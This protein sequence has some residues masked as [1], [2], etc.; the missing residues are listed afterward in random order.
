MGREVRRVPLS[1]QHPTNGICC[2]G[3]L[4]YVPL[5]NGADL[6]QQTA[7]WD[8]GAGAWSLGFC[9]EWAAAGLEFVAR[10]LAQQD[11]TYDKWAGLR[12]NSEDY[13]PAWPDQFRTHLVMCET[14]SEGM[15]ISPVLA[16]LEELARWLAD[17]NAS[18]SGDLTATY[19]QWLSMCRQGSASSILF[20][21]ASM[22]SGVAAVSSRGNVS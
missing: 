6:A 8:A 21:A 15:P 10:D 1:W 19:E 5:Y 7:E 11:C 20:S 18:A 2:D 13:M 17:N 4:Q 3:T 16:P 22:E 9:S 12:P 14:A